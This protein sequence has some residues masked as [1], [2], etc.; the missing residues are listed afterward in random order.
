MNRPLIS[1]ILTTYNSSRT[2]RKVLKSII[3]QNFPLKAVELIIVDGGSRDDTIDVLKD[4]VSRCRNNFYRIE[5]IIHDKNYGVSRARNDG[6]KSSR[7]KYILILDDDVIMNKDTLQV[8][9]NY[10]EQAPK[11][12]GCVIPLHFNIYNN[13][14]SEWKYVIGRGRIARCNFITS[15]ALIRMEVVDKVGLYDETL[16]PPF[17]VYEDVEYGA[18]Y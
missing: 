14:I 16:G 3:D 11:N 12:V 2:I 9:L 4:F 18:K 1:I 10:L 17:T 15:C 5:L 8:L 13:K 7:G 6:I